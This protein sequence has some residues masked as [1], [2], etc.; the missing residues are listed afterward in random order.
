MHSCLSQAYFYPVNYQSSRK[1]FKKTVENI[2]KTIAP[3]LS[4]LS[5]R[6][7]SETDEKLFI[8]GAYFP[9][10]SDNTERL[11]IIT[12]G[13]HGVEAFCGASLQ[14][15]Y[16]EEVLSSDVLKS[17]GVLIIHSVNPY[18]FQFHRRVDE[19]NVDLNRNISAN[20]DNFNSFKQAYK[21][22]DGFLNPQQPLKIG[23]WA[24][25]VLFVKTLYKLMRYGRKTIAQVAVGGQYQNP[26]GIYY[27]GHERQVNGLLIEQVFSKFGSNYNKILHIDLHTGYGERGHLHLISS[28]KASELKGFKSL[29]ENFKIDYGADEN[30][31]DTSGS[32]DHLTMSVFANKEIAIPITFEFGT[33]NSQTIMGGFYS[34]RNSIYENQ[35]HLYGYVNKSSEVEAKKD[36]MEMFNPS[37]PLWRDQVHKTGLK[38]LSELT[39][40]FSQL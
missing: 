38:S 28:K 34:L 27:G 12:S 39:E 30:F 10:Q 15:S 32:F 29:F 17:M 13:I 21:D 3:E 33:L 18:G 1:Q 11:L 2:K 8:D 24:D 31:Y 37:D 6:V 40:R 36:F 7:P 35:G 14:I 19:D 9:Q 4:L 16:L 26:K 25:T 5:L 20:Q 22:F 23:F